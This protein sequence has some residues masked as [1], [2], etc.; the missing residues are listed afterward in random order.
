MKPYPAREYFELP[1]QE[2]GK[3]DPKVLKENPERYAD[4]SLVKELDSQRF[5]RQA[6]AGIQSEV[7]FDNNQRSL[8]PERSEG[9]RLGTPQ[10]ERTNQSKEVP[11]Q[12]YEERHY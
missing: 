9:S 1:I 8:H 12:Q 11:W 10:L 2:V 7:I 4:Q 3:K 6:D 5:Y